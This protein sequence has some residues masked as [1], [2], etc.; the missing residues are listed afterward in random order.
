MADLIIACI[1]VVVALMVGYGVSSYMRRTIKVEPIGV[2]MR[3]DAERHSP[4][5]GRVAPPDA[6]GANRVTLDEE[7]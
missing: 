4:P 3:Y 5:H 6:P 1:P 7:R 2:D